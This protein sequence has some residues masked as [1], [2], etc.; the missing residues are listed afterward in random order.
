[1]KMPIPYG[2]SCMSYN[3]KLNQFCRKLLLSKYSYFPAVF[4]YKFF[5]Y[6]KKYLTFFTVNPKAQT[7]MLI[8]I[9]LY[10]N[11]EVYSIPC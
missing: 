3:K 8:E 11:N 5:D 10:V 9:S 4:F 6:K 2:Y 1:M 7:T